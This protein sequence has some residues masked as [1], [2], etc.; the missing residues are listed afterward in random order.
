M[1]GRTLQPL[2][3]VGRRIVTVERDGGVKT[4][5][6]PVRRAGRHEPE[7]RSV[8]RIDPGR[9][10]SDAAQSEA[11]HG[12]L[13]V[14]RVVVRRAVGGQDGEVGLAAESVVEGGQEMRGRLTVA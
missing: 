3:R 1:L 14:A 5:E 9:D 7:D 11:E 10:D 8:E 6:T 13:V 12:V 4:H 2:E